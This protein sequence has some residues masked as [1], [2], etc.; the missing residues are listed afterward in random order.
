MAALRLRLAWG[1]GGAPGA[2]SPLGAVWGEAANIPGVP[3]VPTESLQTLPY[4]QLLEFS[5]ALS[6]WRRGSPLRGGGMAMKPVQKGTSRLLFSCESFL[7]VLGTEPRASLA[8]QCSP[9]S[10]TLARSLN[11]RAVLCCAGGCCTP[12]GVGEGRSSQALGL[13]TSAFANTL[14]HLSFPL[15]SG[16][17][18]IPHSIALVGILSS[19][20]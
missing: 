8:R 9:P 6:C 15:A 17:N 12:V 19:L 11:L 18:L 5:K 16:Q 3:Q 14:S 20:D 10:H 4:K 2:L 7:L 13:G 1:G